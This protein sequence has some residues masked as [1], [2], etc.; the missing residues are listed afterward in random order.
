MVHDV[1]RNIYTNTYINM[2]GCS[3]EYMHLY[4]YYVYIYGWWFGTFF[5]FSIY[6]YIHI[7]ILGI[8]YSQLIFIFVQR[9]G[10]TTDQIYIDDHIGLSELTMVSNIK[11]MVCP[12][13]YCDL[14]D[15]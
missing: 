13:K 1:F 6:I 8:S 3:N 5:Y 7:Y 14:D 2:Y 10:S 11:D 12:K 9:D 4:L 15:Y